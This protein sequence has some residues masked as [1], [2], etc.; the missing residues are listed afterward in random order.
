[1]IKVWDALKKA[2]VVVWGA[3]QDAFWAT[4]HAIQAAWAWLKPI[5]IAIGQA[6]ASLWSNYV[7]PALVAI[8]GA[9]KGTFEFIVKLWN[10]VLWPVI[11]LIGTVIW[12][13]YKLYFK[14]NLIL[15][16]LAFKAMVWAIKGYWNAY[17][18][19]I[20]TALGKII[21]WLWENVVKPNIPKIVAAWGRVKDAFWVAWR[22]FIKP[23]LEHFK[24]GLQNVWEKVDT[25]VGWIKTAWDKMKKIFAA[26]I[27]FMLK[28]VVND[29][30]VAGFNKIA[31]FVG[32]DEMSGVPQNVLDAVNPDK[33]ASGG[34]YGQRKNRHA[35]GGVLPGYTP[36][37]D[38]HHFSSPSGGS[39][40]LSGGEA[41]M[42]PEFT[43]A[44]GAGWVHNMNAVARAEGV[45]GIRRTLGGGRYFLGGVLPELGAT[46]IK[47]HDGYSFATWAGDLNAPGDEGGNTP[48]RAWKGGKVVH[49]YLGYGDSHGRY[50]NHAIV[51]HPGQASLYAHMDRITTQLGAILAA[52]AQIGYVGDTGNAQGAH[53]HFEVRGGTVNASDMGAGHAAPSFPKWIMAVAK[54]PLGYVKGLISKPINAMKDKFGDNKFIQMAADIPGKLVNGVKNKIWDYLPGPLKAIAKGAGAL[55][56]GAGDLAGG[57]LDAVGLRGSGGD[58]EGGD[59][60]AR[61]GVLPYN[62]TMKYDSGGYLPPGLTSVV[63]LTGRP[64]PV[65]TGDQFDKMGAGSG[66]SFTYAPTFNASDLTAA[67]VARD[68]DHTRRKMRREGRY[69][70]SHS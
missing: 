66:E 41:I 42:R 59:A 14:A 70:R 16:K 37:Q 34:I 60:F 55:V 23:A 51:Q 67:D 56:D 24:T 25:V 38:V 32:S 22:D 53:L 5:F 2:A 17:L 18:K 65:F 36:G 63:N 19:P 21:K 57:A 31:N 8:W 43:K 11:D 49:T 20:F 4:V 15:I 3:I 40:H 48:V 26:P 46:S 10:A 29:G 69:A 7:K 52:G 61:G 39:L 28:T 1:V 64:E 13:L 12:K 9:V 54:N 6:F 62:G 50:G 47:K 30:I 35:G 45:K 68:L 58:P 27:Y 44:M 33:F